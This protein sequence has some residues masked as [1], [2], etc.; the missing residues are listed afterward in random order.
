MPK[1]YV[2]DLELILALREPVGHFS[3]AGLVTIRKAAKAIADVKE[4]L[5]NRKNYWQAELRRRQARLDACL[6][7]KE[8][9][10]CSAEAAAVRQAQESIE[11]LGVLMRRLEQATGEYQVAANRLQQV[12]DQKTG[13]AKSELERIIY[14]YQG[15]LA[16]Q[17][18]QTRAAGYN[19]HGSD[20]KRERHK[21]IL[22]TIHEDPS[23]SNTA[24]FIRNDLLNKVRS[25]GE[26]GY[27]RSP[28][29]KH[30]GH[31]FAGWN[32]WSNFRW[33]DAGMNMHRGGKYKR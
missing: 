9:R 21:F 5:V 1:F 26:G 31:L 16:G 6:S 19:T 27:I 17:A 33:E 30:V 8:N 14:R 25:K 22:N 2:R 29:G 20:Y 7:D 10:G 3:N 4:E 24:S 28:K 13:K 15:Y 23:L 12:L 11:K 32:H 18:R